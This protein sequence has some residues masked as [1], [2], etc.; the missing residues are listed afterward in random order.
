MWVSAPPG[1]EPN[2]PPLPACCFRG[3]SRAHAALL[4]VVRATVP[5]WGLG[6]A[7]ALQG[8]LGSPEAMKPVLALAPAPGGR[9]AAK[10][11][12]AFL[13]QGASG[14]VRDRQSSSPSRRASYCCSA[15]GFR[16]RRG[17]TTIESGV[18][19]ALKPISNRESMVA[20]KMTDRKTQLIKSHIVKDVK[21]IVWMKRRYAQKRG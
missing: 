6:W 13:K 8:W 20:S 5:G 4:P 10:R 15:S 3:P 7:F 2:G 21:K 14:E 11:R 17:E 9:Y 12:V 18:R 16:Q 1:L 19:S